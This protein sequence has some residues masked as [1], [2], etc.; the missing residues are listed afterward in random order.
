MS[1][2]EVLVLGHT[3]AAA[4][5]YVRALDGSGSVG[6]HRMTPTQFAAQLAGPR[7]AE[8]GLSPATRLGVEAIAA[9]VIHRLH[10][11]KRLTYFGQVAKYPG[12]PGA[13]AST[14]TDL[15]LAGTRPKS[16]DL[17]LLLAEYERE[18]AS[19]GVADLATVFELALEALPAWPRIPVIVL[20]L[21]APTLAHRKFLEALKGGSPGTPASGAGALAKAREFVFS[22][23]R[24]PSGSFDDSFEA[25]SAPG[26]GL[27]AVEIARRI[28]LL[29]DTPFDRVAILLRSPER[30][31]FLVE[32][33]LRRAGIPAYFSRGSA[34]PDPAGRAFLALLHCASEQ[35]SASRFAEYLSLGQV[36]EHPAEPE[37]IPPD[38]DT[39]FVAGDGTA[40]AREPEQ[41]PAMIATPIAWE[42]L[43]VDAAVIGG[44]DRWAR[45]LSGLEEEFRLR[46]RVEEERAR[47]EQQLERLA[48]LKQFSLPLVDRLDQLP[49]AADWS[50]WLDHLRRLAA[51]SLNAPDSVLAALAELEPMAGIGPV[52]ID[53]VIQV[54]SERLRF[55]RREPARRRYGQV[56][57]AS[58]DEAR[59]RTF[60]I[61]FLPGLAEGLFPRRTFEDPLLLDEARRAL[62]AELPRREDKSADERDLLR[63]ALGA[64]SKRFVFSY[65]TMDV[66][67]GRPRVPSLFALELARAVEGRVPKLETFERRLSANSEARLG[68]PAPTNPTHAIDNAEYDLSWHS[69]HQQKGSSRYLIDA[70][71]VLARSLRTRYRRWEKKWGESDGL[72]APDAETKAYLRKR[73]LAEAAYS[74]TSLQSFAACPYKFYLHGVYGLR[75][76]EEAAALEQMDPMTRGALFHAVQFEFFRTLAGV[77]PSTLQDAMDTLDAALDRVVNE[78]KEKLAPAIDRVWQSEVADLCTD[79]RGWL[80]IWFEVQREWEPV[81]FE[82]AFGLRTVD[83]HHDPDSTT[84]PAILDGG[85]KVRGSIDLVERHRTRNVLRVTDHKTGKPPEQHPASIGGGATLQPAL[86]GLAVENLLGQPA[87]LGQLFFCTQKGGFTP[88]EIPLTQG[89]RDRFKRTLDI[90][91]TAIETGFLPAAPQKEA[92]DFCDYRPVCGPYEQQRLRHKDKDELEPLLDIRRMP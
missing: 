91:N 7:M 55:L 51:A 64:A 21:Q 35:C 56:F 52:E 57:V 30:Y 45:R 79:L 58:I 6:Y 76:R 49:K 44:H 66:A 24:P 20:D 34:R 54:L 16:A 87:E 63:V 42:R 78:E 71:P 89:T 17:R 22:A 67:Q 36:P 8:L 3:R 70:S 38:D 61:V 43:L 29:P 39:Y 84:E 68:W 50:D 13:L 33:A 28:R 5:E 81:H 46:L 86:Y 19:R 31:Q 83:G 75:K 10:S 18:L 2:R 60:D 15:R 72:I 12:F 27:E 88:I 69:A 11:A 47:V 92:C 37:W 32:E 40:T 65:P 23:E 85:V 73:L 82:Y 14:L 53:E 62:S 4:D 74:P 9:R 25:F 41:E 80:R 48:T 90:I 77:A 59:G 26:E 1:V